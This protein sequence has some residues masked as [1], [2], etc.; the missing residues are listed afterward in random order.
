MKKDRPLMFYIIQLLRFLTAG[1]MQSA[2]I[3]VIA[4]V[5]ATSSQGHAT[6]PGACLNHDRKIKIQVSGL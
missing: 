1:I 6:W 2:V 4:L 3:V 5:A